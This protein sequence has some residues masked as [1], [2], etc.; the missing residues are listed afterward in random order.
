MEVVWECSGFGWGG[1]LGGLGWSG[2]GSFQE[3]MVAAAQAAVG[4]TRAAAVQADSN[5]PHY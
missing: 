5:H 2:G 1:I 3:D 4:Q